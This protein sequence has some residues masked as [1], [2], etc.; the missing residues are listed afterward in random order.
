LPAPLE[1]L[2]S[3]PGDGGGV[4]LLRTQPHAVT[5]AFPAG[6]DA[7]SE[8][9]HFWRYYRCTEPE[10]SG[11]GRA[12]ERPVAVVLARYA[13]QEGTAAIIER[14][15]GRGRVLLFTSTADLEWNDW[16]RAP[17]GSYV[18]TMLELVQY[19]A[20]RTTEPRFF[21]A[22]QPLSVT[23]SPEVYEPAALFKSPAFPNEPPFVALATAPADPEAP[24][25]VPGPIAMQLGTYVVDLTPR[26]QSG[27]IA[28]AATR[29]VCVNLDPAESDLAVA[30]PAALDAAL[31]GIPHE[32]VAT[33]DEF[34]QGAEHTRQELWPALLVLL[35]VTLM[36]EQFLAWWFG[37]PRTGSG[38]ASPRA[39]AG[40]G[41]RRLAGLLRHRRIGRFSTV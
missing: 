2:V 24:L 41:R 27:Y 5:A 9:V 8:Y 4:G 38:L 11:A 16:G 20:R 12:T 40:R 14:D 7:F 35:A 25:V 21:V 18:V 1:S 33:A 26:A 28:P 34:L 10:A 23:L 3:P 19:L 31:A 15:L 13:D 17:D 39:T 6:S 37:K 32:L 36:L 30:G 22:G 29:P